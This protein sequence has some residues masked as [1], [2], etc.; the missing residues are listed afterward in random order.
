[1][2][3]K[4]KIRE[5]IVVE[6]KNDIQAVRRAV[7]AHFIMTSGFGINGPILEE[8]RTAKEKN[9]V[10]VLTDPD[11]MGER[12]REILN[13]KIPGLKHAYISRVEGT[14]KGDVGVENAS[15]DA[16]RKALEF[17]RAEDPTEWEE[18]ANFELSVAD[19]FSMGLTGRPGSDELRAKVAEILQI[20]AC[21]VK[22]FIH[23]IKVYKIQEEQL[24]KA[25]DEAERVRK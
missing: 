21:N 7:D 15:P 25:L 14:T 12:I 9:G 1:M 19:I 5:T 4:I 8:I 22:Q 16:I 17:A 6:G 13:K 11:Y 24:R 20:G 18:G 2:S 23:R 3:K 10:I